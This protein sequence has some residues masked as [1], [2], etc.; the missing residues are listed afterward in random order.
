MSQQTSEIGA[1]DSTLQPASAEAAPRE[2]PFRR[3]PVETNVRLD[4]MLEAIAELHRELAALTQQLLE[5]KGGVSALQSESGQAVS[6]VTAAHR[7]V[8]TITG[9]IGEI[10]SGVSALQGESGETLS[11]VTATHHELVAIAQRVGEIRT[12]L[13]GLQG[14]SGEALSRRMAETHAG[15][16][17]LQGESGEILSHIVVMRRALAELRDELGQQFA[18]VTQQIVETKAGVSALQGNASEMLSHIVLMR[19]ELAAKQAEVDAAL[20]DPAP[21]GSDA[22]SGLAQTRPV[23][24]QT[25]PNSDLAMLPRRLDALALQLRDNA[26]DASGLGDTNHQLAEYYAGMADLV[27]RHWLRERQ[28]PVDPYPKDDLTLN[29]ARQVGAFVRANDHDPEPGRSKLPWRSLWLDRDCATFLV[30][31]NSSAGNHHG[32]TNRVSEREVYGLDFLRMRCSKAADPLLGASGSGGSIWSRLGDQLI[33]KGFCRR[34]LFMP[35]ALAG[36]EVTDW[37]PGASRHCRVALA[38]SRLRKELCSPLLPFTAVLWHPGH[39]EKLSPH[40]YRLHCS[41][42]VAD[43]RAQGIF[44]P[45]FVAVARE[46]RLATKL[47][48]QEADAGPLELGLVDPS[49]GVLAGPDLETIGEDMRIRGHRFSGRGL[50]HAAELWLEVISR[51]WT[52]LERPCRFA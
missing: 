44:A 39:V 33:E 49:L 13:S 11:H 15:V 46:K 36:S 50:E 17:A 40:A 19:R 4:E 35:L 31:G 29:Y 41:D 16:S 18:A 37:I 20:R 10:R 47:V 28:L 3:E 7:E 48:S 42:V 14:E 52:L 25:D 5:T 43:L 32:E 2:K 45:V 26:S 51:N 9:Q 22:S 23:R 30:L 8:A 34:V 27:A 12:G 24:G 21:E 1:D 6:H 38:L